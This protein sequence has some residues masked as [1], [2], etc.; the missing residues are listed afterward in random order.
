M[1]DDKSDISGFI[2][3]S[4][5]DKKIA[6]LAAKAELKSGQDKILKLTAFDSSCFRGKNHFEDD[7]I[8]NYLMFK[9]I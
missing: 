7:G 5:V 8:Q 1:L 6:T 3:N 4:Y 9:P 2:D